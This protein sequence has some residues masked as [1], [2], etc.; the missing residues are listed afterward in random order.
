METI[1]IGGH[2]VS[3]E[4]IMTFNTHNC[5]WGHVRILV[6]RKFKN[7]LAFAGNQSDPR[8]REKSLTKIQRSRIRRPGEG[9]SLQPFGTQSSSYET[10][11]IN[12]AGKCT[13]GSPV[14]CRGHLTRSKMQQ[15][16][17]GE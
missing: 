7:L 14:K 15:N 16:D 8:E 11:R 3:S 17:R 5:L 4:C 10:Q 6:N 2:L 12:R 1:P 9:G 13:Q